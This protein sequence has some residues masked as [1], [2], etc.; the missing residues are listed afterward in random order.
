VQLVKAL[1]PP[2][3]W[4]RVNEPESPLVRVACAARWVEDP[5]ALRAQLGRGH[6]DGRRARVVFCP[7]DP[8][9]YRPTVPRR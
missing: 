5:A 4:A 7:S 8:S 2:V 6:R 9:R 3:S 1:Q